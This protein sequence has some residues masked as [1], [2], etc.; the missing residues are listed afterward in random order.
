MSKLFTNGILITN[1]ICKQENLILIENIKNYSKLKLKKKLINDRNKYIFDIFELSKILKIKI[2]NSDNDTNLN[3]Y[4]IKGHH[5]NF[6]HNK[7]N[8]G[9]IENT[10][11]QQKKKKSSADFKYISKFSN[12]DMLNRKIKLPAEDT[13]LFLK[14]FKRYLND[15][16]TNSFAITENPAYEKAN[17]D[18]IDLLD[19]IIE[20]YRLEKTLNT[21]MLHSNNNNNDENNP[22]PLDAENVSTSELNTEIDNNNKINYEKNK[23]LITIEEKNF[24]EEDKKDLINYSTVKFNVVSGTNLIILDKPLSF[25]PNSYFVFNW[26]SEETYTSNAIIHTSN[27]DWLQ[28]IEVKIPLNKINSNKANEESFLADKLTKNVSITVFS[29]QIPNEELQKLMVES[30][31]NTNICYLNNVSS[32]E[33]LSDKNI[34]NPFA[35]V[36][37]LNPSLMHRDEF[38]GETNISLF[39]ILLNLLEE[40]NC[41]Y[42]NYSNTFDFTHD[43]FYHIYNRKDNIVG[44][45]HFKVCFE[46]NLILAFKEILSSQNNIDY[47]LNYKPSKIAIVNKKFTS[48]ASGFDYSKSGNLVGNFDSN[49]KINTVYDINN[50]NSLNNFLPYSENKMINSDFNKK[51]NDNNNNDYNYESFNRNKLFNKQINLE[52][53]DNELLWKKIKENEVNFKTYKFLICKNLFLTNHS[54]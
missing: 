46:E 44:Q 8:Q 13:M 33:F 39:D 12:F 24:V 43:G 40:R 15:G 7:N 37:N 18:I 48:A 50:K 54:Q 47:N 52:E 2:P 9:D 41:H 6:N 34:I 51:N 27:P 10:L 36:N 32:Q 16:V 26:G 14:N 17:T 1:Q 5:E 25:K 29:K 45:I 3:D 21:P 31:Q 20:I 23:D 30:N 35:T 38:I 22:L 28:E 49:I 53:L 19:F 4:N 11:I 42:N